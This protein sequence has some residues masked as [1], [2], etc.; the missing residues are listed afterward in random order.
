MS[1]IW[2]QYDSSIGVFPAT[3]YKRLVCQ[4]QLPSFS[5]ASSARPPLEAHRRFRGIKALQP[6]VQ[7]SRKLLSPIPLCS[8]L[9]DN[10]ALCGGIRRLPRFDA[11][12]AGKP[13][14]L[15]PRETAV[16]L[17]GLLSRRHLLTLY[18]ADYAAQKATS[19]PGGNAT[20]REP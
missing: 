5:T 20:S 15:L 6:L 7:L 3:L 18:Y 2:R 12:A 1:K 10:V 17:P 16:V 8:P 11:V 4:S 13:C 19:Y 9:L 14:S